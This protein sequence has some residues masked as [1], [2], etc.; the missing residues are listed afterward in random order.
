MG[1]SVTFG[2]GLA[3]EDTWPMRME[4]ALRADPALKDRNVQVVNGGVPGWSSFQGMRNLERLADFEPDVL[5]FWYGLADAHEMYDLPDSAQVMPVD[6][7]SRVLALLW[8]LRTFQLVEKFVT[9]ARSAAAEGTRVSAAEY[10]ANVETLLRRE[11]E[12][13]PRV[14]FVHEPEQCATALAQLRHVLARAEEVD[15]ELVFGPQRL[16]TWIT[17]VPAQMDL[18]GRPALRE[19][20]RAIVFDA[21]SR[22]WGCERVDTKFTV[23]EVRASIEILANLKTNFDRITAGLPKDALTYHDLF[24]TTPPEEVYIDNCHLT[25]LGSRLAG[26]AL[27]ARVIIACRPGG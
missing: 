23:P 17:P 9:G 6:R 16:L 10:R 5:V 4:E 24:G 19:D 12:G 7:V 1:D 20:R 2:L 8:H 26:Q 21:D 22:F 15:A 11:R 25:P 3:E 27:A 18:T 13:G 14:I